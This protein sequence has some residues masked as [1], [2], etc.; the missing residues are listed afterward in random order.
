LVL[1]AVVAVAVTAGATSLQFL[2]S[3]ENALAKIKSHFFLKLSPVQVLFCFVALYLLGVFPVFLA[4]RK[5]IYDFFEKYYLPW[6]K[7]IYIALVLLTSFTLLGSQVGPPETDL[8]LRIQTIRDKYANVQ[9]KTKELLSEEVALQVYAKTH[10]S[11]PPSYRNALTTPKQIHEHVD[12]LRDFYERV[13]RENGIRSSEAESLLTTSSRRNEEVTK[14]ETEIRP[15]TGVAET[16]AY[17]TEPDPEQISYRS[18]EEAE[19]A[20]ESFKQS[21]PSRVITFFE[22]QEGKKIVLQ[23]EKILSG[24]LKK[25]AFAS[26]I[27][28]WPYAEPII[29]VFV[30]TLDDKLKASIEKVIDKVTKAIIEKPE[31]AAQVIG[32]NATEITSQTEIKVPQH[33]AEKAGQFSKQLEREL[34][35]I[36]VANESIV[37]ELITQLRSPTES[38][39]MNAARSL[40]QLGDKISQSKAD[41]IIDIMR[42]GSQTWTESS[43]EEG[44]HCTW[45]TYTPIRYYA[46]NALASMKSK[47][48][49]AKVVSEA[50]Q[51]QANCV[52]SKKVTDPGWI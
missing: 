36:E 1:V 50:Q 13:R 43:R 48:V 9:A 27:K 17:L 12:S 34:A 21:R 46:A 28:A 25:E 33:T 29:D 10:D 38:V 19:T 26:V 31:S 24:G 22:S 52:T 49:D 2:V 5:K 41:Q 39:R 44:H 30:S 8:Q 20:V 23:V 37:G 47:Y 32:E 51:C 45:Y 3:F 16:K 11:L 18:V 7:R 35:G 4:R 15:S 42:H 40:S 14:L 6:T